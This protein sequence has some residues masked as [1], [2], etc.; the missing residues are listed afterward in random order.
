MRMWTVFH[1]ILFVHNFFRETEYNRLN[2]TSAH[3][4]IPS[5]ILF[6]SVE[7]GHFHSELVCE[8]NDGNK[9]CR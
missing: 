1:F 9:W 6:T 4:K 5:H 3:I 7:M 8:L 2:A